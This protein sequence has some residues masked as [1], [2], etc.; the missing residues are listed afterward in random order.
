MPAPASTA[1]LEPEEPE[2]LPPALDEVPALEGEPA[3]D[4]E[5]ALDGVPALDDDEPALDEPEP[6]PV[7]DAPESEGE[8]LSPQLA[9]MTMTAS[10]HARLT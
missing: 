1:P 8:V 2:S 3:L 4:D 7:D 10:T 6:P 5:P 9:D